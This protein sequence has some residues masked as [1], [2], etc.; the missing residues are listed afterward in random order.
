MVLVNSVF[1]RSLSASG[2]CRWSTTRFLFN[3]KTNPYQVLGVAKDSDYATVKAAFLKAAMKHHPDQSG[4]QE[5][6]LL[7]RGAFEQIVASL[8]P[9]SDQS[10][11]IYASEEEF[12]AWFRDETQQFL[13]FE[14]NDATVNEVVKV[15]QTMSPS[16]KDKGG[17]W[18]MARLLAERQANNNR[19]KGDAV[20]QI[21][22]S[23]KPQANNSLRRSRK[24]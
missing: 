9:K 19:S 18:E 20:A 3:S 14:M 6:F 16:G 15:F 12:N 22:G 23:D 7:V 24:R 8:N 11:P 10:K 1:R 4:S 5:D 2:H 17:Y 13:S 21:T